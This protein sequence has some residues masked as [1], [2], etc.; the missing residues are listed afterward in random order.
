MEREPGRQG[1]FEADAV[2]L[3]CH[4]DGAARDPHVPGQRNEPCEIERGEDDQR[5]EYGS[6]HAERR[7]D[8]GRAEETRRG[9]RCDPRGDSHSLEGRAAK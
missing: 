4:R 8:R 2:C 6:L 9:R 1:L 7:G 3:Q 5:R